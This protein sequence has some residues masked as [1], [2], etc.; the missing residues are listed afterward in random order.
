[1]CSPPH[2]TP[3][4]EDVEDNQVRAF[5][6]GPQCLGLPRDETSTG[7]RES[8]RPRSRASVGAWG[9]TTTPAQRE[10]GTWVF[11]HH[12]ANGGGV[13]PRLFSTDFHRPV[14][15]PLRGAQVPVVLLRARGPRP[16]RVRW[17][18]RRGCAG[19][20]PSVEVVTLDSGHNVQEDEPVEL[21]EV[22][23]AFLQRTSTIG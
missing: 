6:A 19:C 11:K 14:V 22:V 20:L 17:E 3:L 7:R 9:G 10:D 1:M 8:A 23:E 15:E 16:V 13:D 18:C 4:G 2:P 12:L 21:A 5:L